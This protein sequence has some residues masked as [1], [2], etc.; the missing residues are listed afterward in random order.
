[1]F[2]IGLV[3]K[4]LHTGL[5]LWEHKEKNKY[6][7]KLVKLKKEFYAEY[8]KPIG[9]RSDAALDDIEFELRLI[10]EAW[11]ASAAGNANPK[12]HS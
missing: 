1:M 7:D 4:I 6:L 8:S 3:L 2:D 11:A 12:T 10:A 5:S 9:I